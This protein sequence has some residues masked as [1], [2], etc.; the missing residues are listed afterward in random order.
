MGTQ[1][2]VYSST[3][4]N[5]QK[6]E[7]S[8]KSINRL[9]NKHI[10]IDIYNEILFSHKMEWSNDIGNNMDEPLKQLSDKSQTQKITYFII[11]LTW[12]IQNRQIHRGR[13]WID[14]C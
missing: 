2:H 1:T 7:T 10:I 14:C 13:L 5:N 9:M 12:N 11:P 6:A 8:Q 3:I 4:H